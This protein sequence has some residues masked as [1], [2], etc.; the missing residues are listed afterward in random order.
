MVRLDSIEEVAGDLY[1]RSGSLDGHDIDNWLEAETIVWND[2]EEEML[3][4]LE[5][6]T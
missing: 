3:C 4:I 6:R 1:L 2:I 5:L